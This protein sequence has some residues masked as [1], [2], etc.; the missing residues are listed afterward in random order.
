MALKR[1]KT[2]NDPSMEDALASQI[3]EAPEEN[4][5]VEEKDETPNTQGMVGGYLTHS[6]GPM[7]GNP[8][9]D[10]ELVENKRLSKL[11]SSLRENVTVREGWL[12]VDRALLGERSAFYPEKWEFM[13]RPAT[14]DAIRN[15]S[16]V[17]E[18]NQ[19]NVDDVFNEILKSCL[20]IR[21]PMGPMPWNSINSWDRFF[22]I[23]LIREYTFKTGENTIKFTE[24]C[25]NCDAPVE[26]TLNSLALM[27]DLPDQEVMT[28][29]D[30]D[31]RTWMIDP[32][33]FDI[34]GQDVIKLYNPTVEKDANIKA[35]AIAR[36][37][38]NPKY[39]IDG[40]FLKFLSWMA[41]KISKDPE[42][43]KRQIREY[44][45]KYMAFDM[46][47]F[48]LM[49]DIIKNISVTPSTHIKAICPSCGEEVTTRL[50]FPDG[51]SSLFN[52]QRK[53]R[54][55]GKK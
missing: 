11:G 16:T 45:N 40:Q 49:D 54:K 15:W 13:I 35:W 27:W 55:F 8:E 34:E 2:T 33:E 41:P 28:Y 3:P 52:I 39:K 38:E 48:S 51:I 7:R 29:Y 30:P 23:M 24:D 26:F 17:D 19:Y 14:V 42:I 12:H 4:L 47:M 25:V 37:Q 18:E 1:G 46:D 22:F 10:N 50:K 43:A 21:T 20:A 6:F 5:A 53:G 9:A 31:N 36:L 32:E 44:Q